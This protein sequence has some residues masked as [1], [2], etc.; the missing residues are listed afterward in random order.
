VLSISDTGVGMDAETQARIFEPFFTTKEAGK[1]TGLGLATVY[2]IIKQSGGSVWVYSEPGQGAVFKV[3]LPQ[4]EEP[5][6]T[7]WPALDS[8]STPGGSETLLIVEDQDEVRELARDILEQ[9]GYTVL[10]AGDGDTAWRLFESH[11]EQVDLL[12]TDVVMPGSSG[13]ALADRVTSARPEVKV[14]YMSGYTD[15]AIVH[16]GVLE[17]GIAYLEKPFSI[18]SLTRAVRSTLDARAVGTVSA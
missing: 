8:E 18:D 1:G 10:D 11:R 5:A 14:L 16:H 17:Q 13:R 9:H 6:E 7:P 15:Q 4:A 3:Y 2:G 12:L